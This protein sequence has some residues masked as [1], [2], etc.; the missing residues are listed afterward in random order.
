M[1]TVIMVDG[2]I[3]F[4]LALP[5][6]SEQALTDSTRTVKANIDRQHQN[7]QSKY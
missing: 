4:E 5:E 1:Y 7:S 6:Q 2:I 3:R